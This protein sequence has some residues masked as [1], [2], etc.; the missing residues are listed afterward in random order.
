MSGAAGYTTRSALDVVLAAGVY[1]ITTYAN[2]LTD[3]ELDPAFEAFRWE[4]SEAGR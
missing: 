1:A 2:R 3:A 4:P